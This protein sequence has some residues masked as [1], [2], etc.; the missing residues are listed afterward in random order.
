MVSGVGSA[1]RRVMCLRAR[2]RVCAC[3]RGPCVSEYY[4]R[5]LTYL[6][7]SPMMVVIPSPVPFSPVLRTLS[8]QARPL[9]ICITIKIIYNTS[10]AIKTVNLVQFGTPHLPSHGYVPYR[11]TGPTEVALTSDHHYH[12]M[13]TASV[14]FK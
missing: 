2:A 14:D 10:R 13:D 7:S 9:Y 8:A 12:Q 6:H 11:I 1:A 5:F 3:V 4:I